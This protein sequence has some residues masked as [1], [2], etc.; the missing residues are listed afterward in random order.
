MNSF[1]INSNNYAMH[2][3]N[4]LY[5]VN[6]KVAMHQARLSTGKRV[7]NAQDDA[8]AYAIIKKSQNTIASNKVIREGVRNGKNL[9]TMVES[10]LNK[11]ME[12]WQRVK[13][14]DTQKSSGVLSE[15]QKVLAEN[16]I[17]ALITEMDD[18]ANT[19]KWNGES[20]LNG[21]RASIDIMVGEGEKMTIT[22]PNT[23]STS[24]GIKGSIGPSFTL[25]GVDDTIK[26]SVN[27]SNL[28]TSNS[29]YSMELW[30]KTTNGTHSEDNVM[31]MGTYDRSSEG[32]D[33]SGVTSLTLDPSNYGQNGKVKFSMDH[34]NHSLYSTSRIDDN[35]WHHIAGVY[36]KVNAK[37]SIFIDGI[38]EN[39]INITNNHA[40]PG[41][42]NKFRVGGIQPIIATTYR[43]A[44]SIGSIR[45]SDNARYS[46]DFSPSSAHNSDSNTTG[47]WNVG[48]ESGTTLNDLSENGNNLTIDYNTDGDNDGWNSNGPSDNTT[49]IS[50]TTTNSI[51]SHIQSI[52]SK[53]DRLEKK[54]EM[55]MDQG[56]A[57]EAVRSSFEDADFAEEQVELIKAQIMQQ[58]ATAALS[59]AN[60]APQ[61]VLSLFEG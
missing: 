40:D 9:L 27:S 52:G 24:L 43:L 35:Q 60:T 5:S 10:S 11:Q 41:N 49:T 31:L 28:F 20:L 4:Q 53:L 18:I 32:G 39:E 7:N 37:A 21:T 38:K 54:E 55:L 48:E 14:L 2:A 19:T 23:T 58:T 3:L 57:Q 17:D 25:D 16:Q 51:L 45:I 34:L 44:G 6:N 12:I 36:D 46:E 61:I 13:E 26:S 29:S 33:T 56:M 50:D 47:L 1:K 8:A 42:A 30:Y 22:L 59:Q 15:N